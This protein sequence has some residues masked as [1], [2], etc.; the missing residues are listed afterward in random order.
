MIYA[1]D[2]SVWRETGVNQKWG[3]MT[4]IRAN[5]KEVLLHRLSL[6]IDE[7]DREYPGA[8]VAIHEPG[9]RYKLP[10]RRA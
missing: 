3:R 7:W 10:P 5:T 4:T 8:D 1:L 6:L 2:V 9:K